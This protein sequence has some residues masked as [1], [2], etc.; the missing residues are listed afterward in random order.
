[1]RE[2]AN[3]SF[4]VAVW[5]FSRY[6]SGLP[7]IFLIA[8]VSS[9]IVYFATA[10]H[11]GRFGW[12]LLD[13]FLSLHAAESFMI[14]ISALVPHY[15]VGIAVAAG[16]YGMFMLCQGF[17]VIRDNIPDYWIW[18]HYVSVVVW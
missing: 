11:T 14:L 10:L 17:M 18:G 3:G 6:V 16:V 8:L 4:S 5:A 1:M 12:F 13:L 9:L 15:I 7:G 2:R